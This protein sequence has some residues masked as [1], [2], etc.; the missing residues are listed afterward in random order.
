M[1]ELLADR[2][3]NKEIAAQLRLSSEG[4]KKRLLGVYGK[5][6]VHGR[7]EAVAEALTRG[8]IDRRPAG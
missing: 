7:R 8:L 4:V 3:T 5:L 1:L 6:G 2:L